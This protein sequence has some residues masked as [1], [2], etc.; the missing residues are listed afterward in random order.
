[1]PNG[2]IFGRLAKRGREAYKPMAGIR[3]A[4]AVIVAWL[5]PHG[6]S[7][8]TSLVMNSVTPNGNN[9]SCV[10]ERGM[11]HLEANSTLYDKRFVL[12]YPEKS[13]SWNG[14]LLVGS[15]GGTGGL[16]R[17]QTGTITD[18]GETALDDV[19]GANA[20]DQGYAY[21]SVDRDG[22][23]GTRE[24]LAVTYAFTV[25]VRTRLQKVFGRM[26]ARIYL[27]G[28]SA[29]GAI[30]RYAAEDPVPH[31]DGAL[32]IAGGGGAALPQLERQGLLAAS[33]PDVDPAKHPTL[34]LTD[35][36]VQAYA[37]AIGT[38]VE[39][40]RLWPFVGSRQSIDGFRNTLEQLGLKGLSD[41]QLRAFKMNDYRK[42]AVFTANVTKVRTENMTGKVTIPVIEV[43]GTYDDIAISGVRE[44]HDRL[45]A[46]SKI[47]GQPTP[48]DRHRL[49]QVEGV[50]H[51]STDDDA[52]GSFQYTMSQMGLDRKSQNELAA[53]GTYIPTVQQAFTYLNQW[54]SDGKTP[55][56]DQIVKSGEP[57]H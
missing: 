55:P 57:L 53:G 31:F 20:L 6:V 52:I 32:I 16:S 43:V 15:H 41:Q 14:R 11:I 56:S 5:I 12:R 9:V 4:S 21:A 39:A 29:G 17:S 25:A 18:T 35:P 44:Y 42:N 51:I 54:V 48:G 46:V 26:P 3:L 36:K 38:P 13:A 28:L 37:A 50:W 34:S 49:Y 40:R 33:W 8:Q 2:K 24:G 47:A 7:A 27:A 30:T 10:E 45:H 23:G 1:M 22:I 19:I